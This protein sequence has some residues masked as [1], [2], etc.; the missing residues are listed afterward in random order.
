MFFHKKKKVHQCQYSKTLQ[1]IR[2][3]DKNNNKEKK[4]TQ[5]HR[6]NQLKFQLGT[7]YTY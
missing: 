2:P 7:M 5:R 4:N 6:A 3:T 1:M